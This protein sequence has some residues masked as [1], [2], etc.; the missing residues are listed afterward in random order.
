MTDPV[1]SKD[2]VT[3]A[4]D[5]LNALVT[6]A[7][8]QGFHEIGYSPLNVIDSALADARRE[9]VRWENAHKILLSEIERLK[10]PAHEREP[11]HC[12]TCA[13]GLAPE[14]AAVPDTVDFFMCC[15]R[16]IQHASTCKHAGA[17][18]PPGDSHG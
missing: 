18:Q 10:R 3:Q 9:N 11:P 2:Q 4:W 15:N 12:S 7:Y 17:A 8:E 13:C 16:F 1:P 5:D 6:F 14:P